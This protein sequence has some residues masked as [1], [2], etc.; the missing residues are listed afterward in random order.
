MLHVLPPSFP[1]RRVSD[2]LGMTGMCIADRKRGAGVVRALTGVRKLRDDAAEESVEL[3]PFKLVVGA[4]L[5]FDDGTPDIITYPA[6][7][8]GWGRLTRMLT[9]GNRR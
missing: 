1:T 3:P 9:I 2:L 6:T 8:H 4:R 7:R 5:V